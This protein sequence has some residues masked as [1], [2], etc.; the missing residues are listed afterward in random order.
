MNSLTR[1]IYFT[2]IFIKC[3]GKTC[4]LE[5]KYKTEMNNEDFGKVMTGPPSHGDYVFCFDKD[6]QVVLSGGLCKTIKQ[7][8]GKFVWGDSNNNDIYLLYEKLL[9]FH[10]TVKCGSFYTQYYIV[11]FMGGCMVSTNNISIIET[12]KPMLSSWSV[13]EDNSNYIQMSSTGLSKPSFICLF[14]ITIIVYFI[15]NEFY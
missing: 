9:L 5:N 6:F 12:L 7:G 13:F 8:Y 1:S 10:N 14:G 15:K 3:F 2:M 4:V 11:G